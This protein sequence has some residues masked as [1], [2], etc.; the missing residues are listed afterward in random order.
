MSLPPRL[1]CGWS[2][3]QGAGAGRGGADPGAQSSPPL[4]RGSSGE[5]GG[6]SRRAPLPAL[7]ARSLLVLSLLFK[8]LL[9][10]CAATELERGGGIHMAFFF[11]F[12][13]MLSLSLDGYTT[14]VHYHLHPP[15]HLPTYTTYLRLVHTLF[16]PPTILH[17][18]LLLLPRVCRRIIGALVVLIVALFFFYWNR[19]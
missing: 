3:R 5:D 10:C 11:Y 17:P 15:I 13:L 16:L 4:L 19:N 2:N 12:A 6:G 8:A 7:V 9:A 1:D 18:S 14:P